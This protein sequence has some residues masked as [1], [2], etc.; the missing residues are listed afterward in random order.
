MTPRFWLVMH[1]LA[2]IWAGLFGAAVCRTCLAGEIGKL[3][4]QPTEP[5]IE[6]TTPTPIP[7]Q[8]NLDA[9]LTCEVIIWGYIATAAAALLFQG[10]RALAANTSHME[11][12]GCFMMIVGLFLAANGIAI[13]S[14]WSYTATNMIVGG[15]VAMIFGLVLSVICE[16]EKQ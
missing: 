8:T 9:L 10:Y 3:N 14:G 5:T 16:R 13:A 15:L 11:A 1:I 4:V 7:R 6:I 2:L 12:I